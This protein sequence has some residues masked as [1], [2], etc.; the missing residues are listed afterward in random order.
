MGYTYFHVNIK[1]EGSKD[2]RE[3]AYSFIAS[4]IRGNDKKLA[5]DPLYKTFKEETEE[6]WGVRGE[7]YWGENYD[8]NGLFIDGDEDKFFAGFRHKKNEGVDVT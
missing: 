3:K 8:L 4:F 5:K 6:A 1:M 2:M 7:D